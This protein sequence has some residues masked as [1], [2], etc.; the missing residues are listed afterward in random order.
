MQL[1]T[2]IKTLGLTADEHGELLLGH[3]AE[4]A[5]LPKVVRAT[6]LSLVIHASNMRGVKNALHHHFVII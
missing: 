3:V 5:P 4:S 2:T 1:L 6:V